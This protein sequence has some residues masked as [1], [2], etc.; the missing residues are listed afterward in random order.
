MPTDSEVPART[1][2][3]EGVLAKDR[4]TYHAKFTILDL[5]AK[6]GVFSDSYLQQKSLLSPS[7]G[8]PTKVLDWFLQAAEKSW[9]QDDG[10]RVAEEEGG[11]W[12]SWN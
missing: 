4:A 5:W 2:S 6:K 12:S 7:P 10:C 11:A 8:E 1:L 3:R 9:N